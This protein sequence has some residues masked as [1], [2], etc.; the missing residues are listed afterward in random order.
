MK[1]FLIILKET[2]RLGVL[3]V[4]ELGRLTGEGPAAALTGSLIIGLAPAAEFGRETTTC[5]AG[6]LGFGVGV[7]K[8]RGIIPALIA[9]ISTET[10]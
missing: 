7:G 10:L 3:G 1:K 4:A 6:V 8:G 9:A 5:D 2:N